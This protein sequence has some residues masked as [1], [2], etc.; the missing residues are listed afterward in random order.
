MNSILLQRL[1]TLSFGPLQTW[2]D[3]GIFPLLTADGRLRYRTLGEA[4]AAGDLTVAEVS[5]Q[6]SVPELLVINRTPVPVLLLD[7]EEVS[8]AKQNR[9]LNTTILVPGSC[10]TR[11]PV[12]CTERG[13][14]SYASPQFQESP[15][16]MP[17]ALRAQKCCTV[18]ESLGTEQT[19][20]A[21]QGQVWAGI[22]HLKAAAACDA[23]TSAMKD[24]FAS[25]EGAL[26]EADRAF[27]P[28]PGQVGLLVLAAGRPAG[29]DLVSLASAYH[30][31]HPKLVRSHTLESLWRPA[32]PDFPRDQAEE[33][34]RLLLKQ[35]TEAEER[36]FRPVGLGV[37]FRYRAPGLAGAAL[38]HEEEAVHTVFFTFDAARSAAPH[39][40]ASYSQR[41]RRFF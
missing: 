18:S 40:M 21:N 10:E 30:R 35:C 6:G 2:R 37:D 14:W 31:L 22:E 38:L 26:A 28:L 11:I 29:F 25:Q 24:V 32:V 33:R 4:L 23:P 41:Q 13:R 39:P 1:T 7:G 16:V 20:H 9:V 36:S 8:G 19:Y 27:P 34:A 5:A 3:L 17:Q 15:N 12:S